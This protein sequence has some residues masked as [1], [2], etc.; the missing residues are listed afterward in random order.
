M[1][2]ESLATVYINTRKLLGKKG[3]NAFIC[4]DKKTDYYSKK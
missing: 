3:G 1:S 2:S 4:S